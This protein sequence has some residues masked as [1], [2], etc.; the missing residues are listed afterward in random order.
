MLHD[1]DYRVRLYLTREIVVL[2]Q[3]WEGHTELFDDMW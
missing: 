1:P 2:F 3:T